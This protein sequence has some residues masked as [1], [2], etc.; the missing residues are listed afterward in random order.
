VTVVQDVSF[1]FQPLL[2]TRTG[3]A[4]A[5]EA[6][7]RPGSGGIYDLLRQA[8]KAG[9]LVET[10]IALAA[11]AVAAAGHHDRTVPLHINLVAATAARADELIATMRLPLGQTGRAT[12][13]VVL[14]ITPPF[15]RVHRAELIRGLAQLRDAGYRIAFDAVGDGDLPLSL[16]ADVGPDLIKLDA[17]LIGGLPDD[18]PSLAVVESLAH[19]CSRTGIRLAAVGVDSEDQLL[20]LNRLGVRLAQ[21]NLLASASHDAT[22]TAVPLPR[23]VA[24][25]IELNAT[26][27]TSDVTAVPLVSDFL[28]PATTLPDTATAE[29][30][31]D[32]F[33]AA[34]S[35]TGLVLV[36][37][38]GK[39]M[40]SV[41]R[42]RF[43]IAVTGP[44]GHA[45]N[46]KKAASRHADAPRVIRADATA[47][48]LLEM[49]SDADWERSGDDIVVTNQSRIC[50]GVVRLSEVVRGVAEAKIE[51]AAALN[52]LTRLPGSEAVDREIDRRIAN[53]EMFV[54]AWLDVDAFKLVN[55][56]VGFAAGDD[57]IRSLGRALADAEAELPGVR[58]GHVGGDDFLIVTE[59]D[60]IAP[61]VTRVVDRVWSTEGMTVTVSLASLVCGVGSVRSYR[62]A[63]RL[64][65]PLKKQAKAVAGSSWVLTRPGAE[66]VEVLR[67]R[68]ATGPQHALRPDPHAQTRTLAGRH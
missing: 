53:N 43:L 47:L 32:A 17:H 30:V 7:A 34:P 24:E 58:V 45:L 2:S 38:Q 14:E 9:R 55:D 25:I 49:V 61:L 22:T 18:A 19:Y 59:L 52:P 65:A 10:D 23:P 5:I 42:S 68:A 40:Y 20:C 12:T 60:E 13:E 51:Q 48:Q 39:P 63:S 67:G 62:E 57:L 6:L 16:L 8:G 4:V 44:Y 27:T 41:E 56:S 64:L 3:E 35:I 15:S 46:A 28:R 29:E 36:D 11:R 31:R 37:G 50:V 66:R 54:V 26:T 1:V 33:A 21:G